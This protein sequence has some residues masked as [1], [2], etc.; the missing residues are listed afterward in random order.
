MARGSKR[1]NEYRYRFYMGWLEVTQNSTGKTYVTDGEEAEL[2][3]D[4][5]MYFESDADL[6]AA[7]SRFF[8]VEEN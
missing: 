6:N 5:A 4:D 7:C 1:G 8:Q 2:F 3:C